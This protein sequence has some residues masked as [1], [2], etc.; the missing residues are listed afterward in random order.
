LIRWLD[1][2]LLAELVAVTGLLGCFLDR[3]MDIWWHLRAGREILAR[4]A[5]PRTDTYIFAAPGAPWIDLHWGFQV[6]AAWIFDHGGFAAL[7]LAAA[8]AGAVAIA[9]LLAA[10]VPGRS[11][12]AVVWCWLPAVFVMSARFYPRPEILSLMCL[13]AYLLVL[14]TADRTPRALWLLVPIQLVWV[15]VQG[16][17]VLGPIVLACWLLGRAVERRRSSAPR[18][19]DR[20]GAPLGVALV[21]LA[22]PYTWKGA[23]FP[24][25]L[26]RRMSSE[27]GFY[28]QHI[29]ELMSIPDL[30]ARS[31]LSSVYLRLSLL[32]LVLT[33]ASFALRR[34]RF[35]HWSFR[36]SVF[37]LFAGLG[38][39]AGRNQPQFALIAGA[40]LAW[41]VGDWLLTRPDASLI[42]RAV[43][44]ILTSAVL[45]GLMLW[46]TTG[47]FYAYAGEGRIAGLGEQPLW[48]AHEAARF[49]A[50]DGMPRHFVAYHEGQ[51]AVLEFHM[52]PDQSV[53]VDP[54]LEVSPR[55]ALERYY[56]LAAD[57][58][59]REPGW[60]E[61]LRG[62]PQPLGFLVDHLSHHA[63]EA[64]L[65]AHGG[66]R[67]IW[68]DPVAG[69]YVPATET[70]LLD[71]HAVDFVGRHF[72]RDDGAAD[73]ART[74]TS[75][76]VP[77]SMKNAESL[78]SVGRDLLSTGGSDHGLGRTLMLLAMADARAAL[79]AVPRSPRLAQVIAGASLGLYPAPGQDVPIAGWPPEAML[80]VSRARYL[81]NR[82]TRLS[83][84]DLQAWIALFGI[85]DALGDPDASWAAGI[86]L[87]ELPARNAAEFEVQRRV[88]AILRNLIAVRAAEPAVA[89]PLDASDVRAIA[90]DLFTR[91]RFLRALDVVERARR[92]GVGGPSP[93]VDLV[94]LRSSLLLF[95][96][97]PERARTAWTDT[98]TATAHDA[99]AARRRANAAFVEGRLAEAIDSYRTSLS[100]DPRQPALRYGLA[101]AHLELGQPEEFIREC[102]AALSS[103]E[104]PAQPAALCRDMAA[105]AK[106]YLKDR[107]HPPA[108]GGGVRR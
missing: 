51:A 87:V 18:W 3:D 107:A 12:V 75:S 88:R 48:H 92:D 16:L 58:I 19:S 101:I 20:W 31:G 22:N 82:A 102:R 53:F 73:R 62:L 23:L 94:D 84:G 108:A 66:W 33:L 35:P 59:R 44:R 32:L 10:T 76:P 63:V 67:C 52:R 55:S 79:T 21:C 72:D 81:L 61:R 43:A 37:V 47:G 30:M 11:T 40:V 7:T 28:A 13:A 6:L 26:F 104:L 78:F 4:H 69:V 41:N 8:V 29:G 17:F 106:R 39:L 74:G 85:A 103:G 60:P 2:L 70:R 46:I 80:G 45:V 93:P 56:G 27:R 71:Q 97:E 90:Q 100:L 34:G 49:A 57:M 5:I 42:E 95:S 9:L 89:V 86:R 15:N 91:R 98:G 36:A 65:L 68:F 99:P 24:L 64:A 96:G 38:L 1:R 50:R 14:R 83:P 105:L 25:T 77:S 54:R